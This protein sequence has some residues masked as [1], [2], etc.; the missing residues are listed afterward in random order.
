MVGTPLECMGPWL[1]EK[2]VSGMHVEMGEALTRPDVMRRPSVFSIRHIDS[3]QA[4]AVD[5]ILDH[6][7]LDRDLWTLFTSQFKAPGADN[8]GGWR[9]EYWGKMMMGAC[10]ILEATGNQRLYEVVEQTV[11]D[12]LS[13]ERDDGR[14]STYDT[15]HE[16]TGWDLW[17]R[18]YVMVG[19]EYFL[20]LCRDD[21]LADGILQ[22]L[23]RQMDAI[24]AKAGPGRKP[25]CEASSLYRG[26]NSSSILEPVVL[27]YRLT[28]DMRY[29]EAACHIVECGGTS[30]FDI[31]SAALE[32]RLLPCEYPI[33]KAYEMISCFEGLIE[34]YRVTGDTNC[35]KAAINFTDRLLESDFT[36]IGS[37]GCTHEFLDHARLRQTSME[38]GPLMQETCV[39][40][41]FMKLLAQVARLT[42]EPRYLDAFETAYY[43]A[44]LG[45]MNTRLVRQEMLLER[46]RDLVLE[47][48]PFDSY[49]PLTTG[50]RGRD[51]GGFQIM[52]GHRFYG[53]CACIGA[54]GAGLFS[55]NQLTVSG[56]T[57]FLNLHDRAHIRT[58]TPSGKP[59][60]IDIDTTY[61]AH[62][63]VKVSLSLETAETFTI[64]VRIPSWSAESGL[65][66]GGK[67]SK[68]DP[69]Y[70]RLERC[71]RNGDT[72][73]LQLDMGLAL[74]H[75][76]RYEKSV[77][78]SKMV[79]E[80]DYMVPVADRP[81]PGQLD[82]VAFRMGPLVLASEEA[83][84]RD[85]DK[86]IALGN[87][88]FVYSVR[89]PERD[90]LA[91]IDLR[92]ADGEDLTLCDYAGAGKEWGPGDRF[93][94]WIRRR[95]ED[96]A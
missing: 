78:T 80:K 86:P 46:D 63:R 72:I 31:F 54:T 15:A 39:T 12:I 34:I 95:R 44:Y 85:P 47:P 58:T 74:L 36:I 83:S 20:P 70:A 73:E 50:W 14:I 26:L 23:C 19:L 28:G 33:T 82:Q 91:T 42:G 37:L 59:L 56:D 96:E 3:P 21:R 30:V 29:L 24:L 93:A 55:L 48:L 75:P 51:V 6:Q 52:E 89:E 90:R 41:S 8:D 67:V 81:H 88:G 79:W 38:A 43:N 69:G 10:F 9:G 77:S 2:E 22:S 84:G 87:G 13:C 61:P 16:L 4:R 49:S 64:A 57:L 17:S 45:A 76:I 25:I 1:V 65:E 11:R 32:D 68:A 94:A 62:G 35:R 71:W 5:F 7:L 18:K 40:V 27:L 60:E 53:C 92:L 66:A